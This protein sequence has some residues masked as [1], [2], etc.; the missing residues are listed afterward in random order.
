VKASVQAAGGEAEAPQP[1]RKQPTQIIK[2]PVT[3]IRRKPKP[4]SFSDGV[5]SLLKAIT[6]MM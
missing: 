3:A 6:R 1:V 2:K 5:R 4:A